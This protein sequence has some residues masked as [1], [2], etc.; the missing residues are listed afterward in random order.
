MILSSSYHNLNCNKL[1]V[2][3]ITVHLHG[4]KICLL[5]F[6][7]DNL[8]DIVIFYQHFTPLK[9][10]TGINNDTGGYMIETS[11][12]ISKC[13]LQLLRRAAEKLNRE[14]SEVLSLL[15][16][17]SRRLFGR[18]AVTGRAVE[19]QKG[20]DG[21]FAIHHISISESDYEFA[22]GRRYLFKISVSFLFALSISR[23]LDEI[24]NDWTRDKASS[25]RAWKR[26][27][28]NIHYSHYSIGH[29]FD[30]NAEF[31][32]IPWPRE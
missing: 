29:S 12:Y 22:T 19:Y 9:R 3:P 11:I 15:L 26:Y 21:D 20:D 8:Q 30:Q 27:R 5:L 25:K 7:F 4:F 23:F 2:K 14:E 31:W 1:Y 16:Q 6:Y 17:K 10:I 28:T 13:R 32:T 24:I 18:C